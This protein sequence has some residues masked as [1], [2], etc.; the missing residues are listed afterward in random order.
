M[1]AGLWGRIK[2]VALTDVTVLVSATFDNWY[3]NYQTGTLFGELT[4]CNNS[5]NVVLIQPFWYAVAPT[6]SVYLVNP[7]GTTNGLEYVDITGKVV[8]ALRSRSISP[9]LRLAPRNSTKKA[10]LSGTLRFQVIH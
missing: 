4:L 6:P 10:R 7:D 2:E 1:R 5:T 8:A 9:S 3:V